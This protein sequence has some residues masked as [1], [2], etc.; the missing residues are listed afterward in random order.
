L[1][2]KELEHR[3][4]KIEKLK[5]RFLRQP[6]DFTW[7]ELQTLLKSMG[8]I[9]MKNSG[10]RRKFYDASKQCL[11]QLH[12]PHP[13]NILKAYAMKEVLHTLKAEGYL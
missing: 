6:K 10:S 13:R 7:S 8:F 5:Q 3:V 11:I 2:K 12:E 1:Q 4:S 9:E